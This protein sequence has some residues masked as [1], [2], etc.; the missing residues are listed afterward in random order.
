MNGAEVAKLLTAAGNDVIINLDKIMLKLGNDANAMIYSRIYQTGTNAEYQDLL[1]YK[2]KYKEY[3][4]K[5]GHYRGFVD[6]TWSGRLWNNIKVVS[7]QGE[8]S[9]GHAKISAESLEYQQILSGLTNGNKNLRA[10]GPILDLNTEEVGILQD[11]VDK[12]LTDI[13]KKNGL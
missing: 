6:L 12:W 8:H 10:R 13:L 2:P 11:E 7:S 5:K 1:S 9:K 4:E 3:K